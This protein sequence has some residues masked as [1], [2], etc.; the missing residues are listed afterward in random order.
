MAGITTSAEGTADRESEPALPLPSSVREAEVESQSP[1]TLPPGNPSAP[2]AGSFH[3][4]MTVAIPLILSSGSVTMMITIDRLFLTWYSEDAL[5][6]SLPAGALHW[7]IM[8]AFVGMINYGNAFVAQYEGAGRK[9]RVAAAVWQGIFLA[10]AAGLVFLMVIPLAPYFFAAAGHEPAVQRY[11]TLFLQTLSCGAVPML[12]TMA[13]ACFYSGRGKTRIVMYVDFLLA[14][15]NI[16]LDPCLIFGLGPFPRLGIVGAGLSTVIA[17]TVAV[18]AYVV[19]SRR[20]RD[21]IEYQFWKHIGLDRELLGRL[22]RYG[23][24]TGLQMTAELAAFTVF[25]VLVGRLGESELAATNLAF[26]VNMMSF[27]PMIGLAMGVMTLVGKRVGERRPKLAERTVWLAAGTSGAYMLFFAVLFVVFPQVILRPFTGGN[28]TVELAGI[29]H[30]VIVLLRFTAVYTFFD[31]M[32]LV[33]AYAIR[34]AGDTRFPFYY[35]LV[36]AWLIMV[37]PTW[38]I[39]RSGHGGL[40]ACWLACSAYICLLGTVCCLRFVQGKWKTMNIIGAAPPVHG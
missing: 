15:T 19:L 25:L 7:T 40:N 34:G 16:A 27:V 21:S 24:P 11:E 36:S 18:I 4:L 2:R 32:A 33:F 20:H 39:V 23:L 10:I 17:Y 1:D 37:L 3:E 22:L 30:T 12:L 5:A 26:N 8:S 28:A 14:A 29:Q 9:D 31:G 6:A 35:T 13:F 38:L